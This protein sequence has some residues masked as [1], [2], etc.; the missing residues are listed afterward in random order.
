MLYI[1]TT[2]GSFSSLFEP[3]RAEPQR[4]ITASSPWKA[5]EPIKHFF[6]SLF[7]NSAFRRSAERKFHNAVLNTAIHHV[8]ER[9]DLSVLVGANK[10]HEVRVLPEVVYE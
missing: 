9:F 6:S 7:I 5:T 3:R 2:G 8:G 10:H 1:V 4:R